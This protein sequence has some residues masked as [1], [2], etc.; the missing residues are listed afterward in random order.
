MLLRNPFADAFGLEIGDLSIKLIRLK[1]NGLFQGKG[2]NIKEQRIVDLPAG[3][4]VNGEIQQPELVRKKL[5]HILGADGNRK[6]SKIKI[7][8]VVAGLP[9]VKT[10]LKLITVEGDPDGLTEDEIIFQAKKHLPFDIEEVYLNWQV[11]AV[12]ANLKH[13]QVLIGAI[14]KTTADT[15][16]YLLESAMLTPIALEIEAVSL[17]RSMITQ[18]K[19]YHGE[20]RAILDLGA[21]RSSLVIYDNNTIQFS[22]SLNFSG[23]LVTMAIEQFLKISHIEAE[24]LKI[25]NGAKYN[26]KNAKYLRSITKINSQLIDELQSALKFYR[27]HFS[28]QNAV[29]HITMCG[30]MSRW[31]GLD[32]LISRKL[33]I[34]AH[35]GNPLKNLSS[36]KNPGKKGEA[37][38][39]AVAIGLALRAAQKP[40]VI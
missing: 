20:A 24:E 12:A 35:P 25:K 32:N 38:E 37:L 17:A 14:Y 7:P 4:I 8:W 26:S 18:S 15:Y 16:T 2:Y 13:T 36:K 11:V 9:E 21:T 34:A 27:D 28:N 5:L 6:F 31:V 10:F 29:N 22:T 30:G 19:D 3:L 23:E 40:F 33:K 39:M 1:A